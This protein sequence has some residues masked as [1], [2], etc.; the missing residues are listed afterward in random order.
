MRIWRRWVF[1]IL[2]IIVLGAVSA[3]L[4]KIAFLPESSGRNSV[5]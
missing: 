2:L 3:A 4:V 1:P 5:T